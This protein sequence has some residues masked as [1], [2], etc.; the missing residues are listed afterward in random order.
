MDIFL[1]AILALNLLIVILLFVFYE[2][3]LKT[4]ES[5]EHILSDKNFRQAI[6]R[7]IEK[8]TLSKLERI[9]DDFAKSVSE[10]VN[11]QLLKISDEAQKQ[12]RQMA[13]YVANQQKAVISE[14]QFLVANNLQKTEG[15]IE[16]YKKR[17][18]AEIDERV[19]EVIA[20][21]AKKVVGRAIS[22]VDHQELVMAA[23]KQAKADKFF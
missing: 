11:G 6:R 16:G 13:E 4:R 9:T 10:G 23:L 8:I 18:L 1:V 12:I 5:E 20:E 7:K 19:G 2:R 3:L 15:E 22:I 21:V 17:K 14:S